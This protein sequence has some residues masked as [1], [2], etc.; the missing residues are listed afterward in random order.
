MLPL[1][2]LRTCQGHPM[3]VEL[4][5]GE[6]YNGFLV[7]IDTWMN[8]NLREVVCTSKDGEK[9]WKVPEIYIRGSA[10]KYLRVPDEIIDVVQEENA[11]RR[12]NRPNSRG[13]GRGRG[14]LT[15][16]RDAVLNF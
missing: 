14:E 7:S 6:T 3:L 11:N 15:S 9:F 2:L 8:L 12:D 13:R 4:K 16:A 10:I 5:T 1:S